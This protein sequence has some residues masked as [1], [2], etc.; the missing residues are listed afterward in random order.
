MKRNKTA[1]EPKPKEKNAQRAPAYRIRNWKEYNSALINRGRVTLWINPE[2]VQAW[3]ATSDGLP[4]KQKV[5]SDLAIEVILSLKILF[6]L[7]LRAAQ[8][9]AMDLIELM[10][11]DLTC[12]NYSTLSRRAKTLKIDL[13]VR[14]TGE[15]IHLL[16][17]STAQVRCAP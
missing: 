6:K 14:N 9:L 8:G 15:P 13:G 17:D 10:G 16:V 11:L 12:P 2:V 7:P 4:H 3:K 5:Y 1:K